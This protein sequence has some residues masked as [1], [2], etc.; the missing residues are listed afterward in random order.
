MGCCGDHQDH[1]NKKAHDNQEYH[2][3]IKKPS[4]LVWILVIFIVGLLVF[5]FVL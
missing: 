5:G 1:D 3:D 2:E 4:W